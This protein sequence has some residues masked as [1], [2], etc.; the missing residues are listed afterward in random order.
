MLMVTY[1]KVNGEMIKHMD[2]ELINTQTEQHMLVIGLKISS[3]EKELKNGLMEQSTM[4]II[5]TERNMEMGVLHLQIAV[6]TQ[7]N[8][9][10]TKYQV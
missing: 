9:R 10:I 5:W 2:M 8:S 4:E 3:M 7:D 6:I 1:T